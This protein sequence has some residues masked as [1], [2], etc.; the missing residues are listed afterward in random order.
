MWLQVDKEGLVAGH[1]GQGGWQAS[2]EA[3]VTPW[4]PRV[5]LCLSLGA[6]RPTPN[7]MV[8]PGVAHKCGG[9]FLCGS[10]EV[11]FQR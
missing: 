10:E 4:G 5:L 7:T 9:K 8:F 1:E 11:P 6:Q 2:G 3:G